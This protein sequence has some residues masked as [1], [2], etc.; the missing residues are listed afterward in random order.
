MYETYQMPRAS[1]WVVSDTCGIWGG[2]GIAPLVGADGRV[3]ELQKM[4]FSKDLR[5]LGWGDRLL[6]MALDR[7]RYLGFESVYLETMPYMKAAQT[8]YLRH[9]FRYLE[10]ALGNTGH[11]ACTVWMIKEYTQG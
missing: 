5:G 8:L 3:C 7:A 10:H 9:G 2:G 6:R 4:Y 1:Y 11:S